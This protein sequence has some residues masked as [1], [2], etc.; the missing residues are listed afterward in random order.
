[1]RRCFLLLPIMMVLTSIEPAGSVVLDEST[2]WQGAI[3]VTEKVRV[4]P[5]VHLDIRPGSKITFEGGSLEVAGRLTARNVLFTGTNWD[6]IVLKGSGLDTLIAESEIRG[7]VT[8]IRVIGGAPRL[9]ELTFTGNDVGLEVRQQSAATVA[10]SLFRLNRKV[11]LFLKDGS[12]AAVVNNRFEEN[13]RYGAYV[14]RSTPRR[15]AGNTFNGHSTALMVAY[16]GSDP[17]LRDNCFERNETAIRIEKGARPHITGS[18]ISGNDV[19][20]S[21]YRRADPVI[22]RNL[23]ADNRAGILIA[24]SSYPEIRNND[25]IGN[26]TAIYLEFQSSQWELSKGESSRRTEISRSAFGRLDKGSTQ[27]STPR[28][29]DGTVDAR[30]NWWGTDGSEELEAIGPGGNPEFI[31]DGR[32]RSTFVEEGETYSLDRVDFG[33]WRDRPVYETGK[34]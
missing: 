4:E 8:G 31:D 3:R 24:F 32:D 14:F 25:F 11:G 1:M 2:V 27:I 33:D 6:G 28:N 7:A 13:G 17:E 29:L 21:L 16:A 20:I 18:D 26:D 19:G 10:G 5:D 30:H 22:E 15:F 23:L 34:N 12:T 9:E